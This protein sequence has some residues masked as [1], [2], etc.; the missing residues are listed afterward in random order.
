MDDNS[1]ALVATA[2]PRKKKRGRPRRK[3]GYSRDFTA[4]P[5]KA[6]RYLLDKIPASLWTTAQTRAHRK[7]LSMRALILQLL[8]D[9]NQQP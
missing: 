8:T 4:D 5:G 2:T 9:W 3:R 6:K 7:G 1:I